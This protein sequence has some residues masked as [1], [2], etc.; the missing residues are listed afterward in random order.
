M[1]KRTTALI[2]AGVAVAGIVGYT[3]MTPS[4]TAST[5]ESNYDE[6]NVTRGD[7]MQSLSGTGTL[8]PADAY[9]V[10]SL[11]SGEV[12]LDNIEEGDNVAKDT[13]LYQIDSTSVSRDIEQAQM[14]LEQSQLNYDRTASNLSD[15]NISAQIGGEIVEILVEEGDSVTT[16]MPLATITDQSHMKVTTAFLA[17]LVPSLALGQEVSVI[18]ESTNEEITGII[19]DISGLVQISENNTQIQDV[20]VEMSN[21]GGLREG[22]NVYVVACE[23]AAAKKGQLEVMDTATISADTSG[24]VSAIFYTEGQQVKAGQQI[25]VLTNETLSNSLVDSQYSIRSSQLS[26][27]RQQESLENYDITSPIAGTIVEKNIKGGEIISG[28]GVLCTIYD[29]SYLTTTLNIDELDISLVHLGQEVQITVEALADRVYSGVITRVNIKGTTVNGVTSYPVTVEIDDTEG[30]LPGMNA[31]FE[32]I[33]ASSENTLLVPIEALERGDRL[34]VY[35]GATLSEG[36]ESD[37]PEGFEYVDV[38]TGLSNED[39]IEI[40]EGVA[41]GDRVLLEKVVLTSTN[42]FG[43]QSGGPGEG[44]GN[45]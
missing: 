29:L 17:Q 25:M 12:I 7:I 37:L 45:D 18:M 1:K 34:I 20:T 4:S 11:V 21:P 22:M 23:V 8:E 35:T 33:V 3:L 39:Y 42:P 28:S 27:E 40:L 43:P 30:L 9:T 32:I 38:V 15:L 19:T 31:D 41:D 10:T 13:L 44:F 14:S 2:I 24:E 5:A 36:T 26:L 16:G 6:V